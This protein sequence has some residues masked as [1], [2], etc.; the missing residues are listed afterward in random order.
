MEEKIKEEIT[1]NTD[2]LS[3]TVIYPKVLMEFFIYGLK[4]DTEKIEAVL[5]K[6]QRELNSYA[7]G[8]ECRIVFYMDN[9]E[10]TEEEKRE[11]FIKN[12]NAYYYVI[13]DWADVPVNFMRKCVV[14]TN[15]LRTA[16]KDMQ[17]YGIHKK[18]QEKVK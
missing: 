14:V 10:L 16:L 15:K 4:K 9:G 8:N 5:K 11:W 3:Q 2:G 1:P 18:I 17:S 12:A 13:L 6:L 7:R